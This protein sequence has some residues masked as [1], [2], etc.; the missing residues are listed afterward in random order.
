LPLRIPLQEV[1][2]AERDVAQ[3]FGIDYI[4]PSEVERAWYFETERLRGLIKTGFDSAGGSVT[5]KILIGEWIEFDS[6]SPA[7]A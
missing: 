5:P 2:I 3:R 6:S 4:L 1:R 7:A